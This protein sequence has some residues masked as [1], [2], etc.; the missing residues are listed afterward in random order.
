[1]VHLILEDGR[2]WWRQTVIAG[3]VYERVAACIDDSLPRLKRWL[4][5]MSNRPV[6]FMDFDLRGLPLE[7]REAFHCAARNARDELFNELGRPPLPPSDMV[8]NALDELVRM[9]ESMDRGDPPKA[10]SNSDTVD[11]YDGFVV[12]LDEIWDV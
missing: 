5:D 1:M 4:H 7:F 10:C 2:S 6:P 8:L 11:A 3:A 9:K 12:D